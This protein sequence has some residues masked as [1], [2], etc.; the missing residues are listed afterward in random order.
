MREGTG[1]SLGIGGVLAASFTL[2]AGVIVAV[3][4]LFVCVYAVVKLI[5][6]PQGHPDPTTL[7]VGAV[8]MVSVLVL[9]LLVGV[10]LL[11]GSLID[12]G[13]TDEDDL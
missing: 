5:V 2:L 12:R 10:R 7:V 3:S 9:G 4:Y 6:D 13:L 1:I 8:L 11:G